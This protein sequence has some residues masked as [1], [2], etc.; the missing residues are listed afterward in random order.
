MSRLSDLPT[1]HTD[2]VI[3]LLER[4]GLIILALGALLYQVYFL[5]SF[6]TAQ[7]DA[8]RTV[9]KE[10]SGEMREDR[11]ARNTNTKEVLVVL[12][13]LRE[14]ARSLQPLLIAIEESCHVDGKPIPAPKPV[15][16]LQ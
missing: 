16:A 6:A 8:W 11:D 10:L 2:G 1:T 14:N 3:A 7:Q 5:A 15:E 12:A 13:G 4:H 9:V